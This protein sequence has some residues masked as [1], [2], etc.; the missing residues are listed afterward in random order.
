MTY[1]DIRGKASA[2][3]LLEKAIR[4]STPQR[5]KVQ[6]VEDPWARLDRYTNAIQE[7]KDKAAQQEAL[8]A[9]QLST[10]EMIWNELSQGKGHSTDIP[11]N[12][13]GVLRAAL[14]GGSGTIHGHQTR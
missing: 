1:N 8:S 9:P 5:K 14:A 6:P 11:L 10:S 12:G 2:K 4:A 13:A 7:R 3:D